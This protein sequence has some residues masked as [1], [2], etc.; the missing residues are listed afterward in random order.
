MTK[1]FDHNSPQTQTNLTYLTYHTINQIH[2][3]TNNDN[4]NITNKQE[5]PYLFPNT[6]SNFETLLHDAALK[7]QPLIHKHQLKNQQPHNIK[8]ST[9]K[10]HTHHHQHTSIVTGKQIG[11]AHV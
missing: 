2:N 7:T 4:Y 11:R 9:P 3:H 6:Q 10:L 1:N 8:H 5:N